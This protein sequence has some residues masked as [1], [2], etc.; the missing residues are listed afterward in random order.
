MGMNA[1]DKNHMREIHSIDYSIKVLDD[2]VAI[3]VPFIPSLARVEVGKGG[4]TLFS[5]DASEPFAVVRD[6]P[7]NALE[8]A[9]Q[10]GLMFFAA[11]NA[12]ILFEHEF[13][14]EEVATIH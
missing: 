7:H 14:P 10:H 8:T 4:V 11:D 5:E 6:I 9:R 12:R 1:E 2:A 13:S 3:F